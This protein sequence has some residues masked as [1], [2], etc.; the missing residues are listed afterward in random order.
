[1]GRLDDAVIRRDE[2]AGQHVAVARVSFTFG[3]VSLTFVGRVNTAPIGRDRLT[4][5]TD[6]GLGRQGRTRGHHRVRGAGG[7]LAPASVAGRVRSRGRGPGLPA[8]RGGGW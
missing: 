3:R 4:H 1:G 6:R 7:G 2:P 5:G 8:P